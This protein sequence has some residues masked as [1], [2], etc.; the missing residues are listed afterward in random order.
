[1][2]N[3]EIHVTFKA[4]KNALHIKFNIQQTLVE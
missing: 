1:M 3:V 2:I 4:I